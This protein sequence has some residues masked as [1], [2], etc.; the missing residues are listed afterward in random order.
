MVDPLRLEAW[1][2]GRALRND[3]VS[4]FREEYSVD[5][6]RPPAL[7]ID[8]LLTD[9]MGVSLNFDQLPLDIFAQT[10]WKDGRPLVTVNSLTGNMTGVKDAS[11]VQPPVH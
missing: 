6:P 8:E 4:R 3:L 1:N 9:F 11:G 2:Y 7:I 10:E 5:V